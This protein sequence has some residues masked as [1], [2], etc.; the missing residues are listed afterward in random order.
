MKELKKKKIITVLLRKCTSIPTRLKRSSSYATLTRSKSAKEEG[1]TLLWAGDDVD[2]SS[3]G[4]A[5][6]V[7]FVGSSRRRCMVK[8][9]HLRHPVISALMEPASEERISVVKCEVVL[10]HHLIWMLENNGDLEPA[11]GGSPEEL[12]ALYA[13]S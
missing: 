9:E 11:A 1:T 5:V 7:V 2:A 6:V 12:A 10:F 3:G 4:E 8:A 13:Y